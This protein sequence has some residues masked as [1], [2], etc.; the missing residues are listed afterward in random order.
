[1]KQPPQQRK[2]YVAAPL[3]SPS[4]RALNAE[5]CAILEGAGT[6][7]LPQRDGGLV[8][9][10]RASGNGDD[11]ALCAEVYARDVRAISE[12]TVILAVLDGRALDEG[13]CIE[14]GFARAQG[15]FVVAFKS[16]V[17]SV[18]PWGQN[19]MVI[20]SVDVWVWS[21]EELKLWVDS[22]VR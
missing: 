4:E 8:E 6:V 17:R 15:A 12:S 2:F 1:M 22:L 10:M 21:L 9:T 13:V 19:P 14:L 20:G 5:I 18:L 11:A 16:D 3:F 7:Y